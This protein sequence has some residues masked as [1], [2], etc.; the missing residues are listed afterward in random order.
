VRWLTATSSWM[1]GATA[2]IFVLFGLTDIP[3][4]T[5][6]N[7]LAVTGQSADQ[8]AASQPQA[9]ALVQVHVR[10]GGVDF[11]TIGLLALAVLWFGFRQRQRWAWWT[12]WLMPILAA[13]LA[14]L[15]V[16]SAATGQNPAAPAFSGLLFAGLDAAALLAAARSFFSAAD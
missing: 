8:L 1:L 4:G 2:A 11:V 9:Y 10:A 15:A 3:L 16:A 7:A 13:T 12:L 5:P 6:D 14:V